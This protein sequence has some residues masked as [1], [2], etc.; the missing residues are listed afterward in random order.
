[1]YI[2]GTFW[3]EVQ[4]DKLHPRCFICSQCNVSLTNQ[5]YYDH[6]GMPYC[7]DCDTQLFCPKCA[8]CGQVINRG[9]ETETSTLIYLATSRMYLS[10]V[11]LL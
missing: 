8:W 1:M 3:T 2:K 10:I 9:M 6:H 11:I 4:G 5:K 7:L